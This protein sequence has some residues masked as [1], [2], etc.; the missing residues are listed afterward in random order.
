MRARI[1]AVEPGNASPVIQS[2]LA[3]AREQYGKVPRLLASMANSPAALRG[4][5]DLRAAL[6]GG[7]L[8]PTLRLQLALLVAEENASR[9]CVAAHSSRGLQ[10]GLAECE[11]AANRRAESDDSKTAAALA[12]AAAVL[13]SRGRV[14]EAEMARVRAAGFSDEEITEIVAHVA[15]NCFGNFFCQLARP[16][17][18]AAPVP[19]TTDRDM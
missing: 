19:L 3:R 12:F 18:D 5:L 11:V 1:P 14:S 7:R 9:Y 17:L 13:A 10:A 4:F 2:L 6:D 16:E 8:S 15:L